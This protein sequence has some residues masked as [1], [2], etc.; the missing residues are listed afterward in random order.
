MKIG[1]D[2]AQLHKPVRV[3]DGWVWSST[4]HTRCPG[5]TGSGCIL[6]YEERP[7]AC[8]LF[9]FVAVPIINKALEAEMHLLLEVEWCPQWEKF[10]RNREQVLKELMK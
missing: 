4:E 8:K 3:N 10:G 2:V 7:L 5:D 9:P 6:A 1:N